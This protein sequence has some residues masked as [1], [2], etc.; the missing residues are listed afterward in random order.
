ME[1]GLLMSQPGWTAICVISALPSVLTGRGFS[2]QEWS[3][4]DSSGI[5]LAIA[6][7]F[8]NFLLL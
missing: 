4:L 2:D 5:S 6:S 8:S 7:F 1:V 3:I